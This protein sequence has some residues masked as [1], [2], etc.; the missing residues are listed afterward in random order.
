MSSWIKLIDPSSSTIDKRSNRNKRIHRHSMPAVIE[1]DSSDESCDLSATVSPKRRRI[2]P[3][4]NLTIKNVEDSSEDCY[5]VDYNPDGIALPETEQKKIKETLPVVAV[6]P[7]TNQLSHSARNSKSNS[8]ISWTANPKPNDEFSLIEIEDSVSD[9][10]ESS[11]HT[12]IDESST[13]GSLMQSQIVDERETAIETQ[14]SITPPVAPF[15]ASSTTNVPKKRK[16]RPKKGGLVE[17]LRK[18]LSQA[19]SDVLFWQHHRSADLIPPGI[20]VSVDRVENTYGRILIHA[21]VNGKPTIFS[22]CSRTVTVAEGDLIEVEF[23]SEHLY[24][25]DSRNLCS[26]VDK[27]TVVKKNILS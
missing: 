15:I 23:D 26:Y 19:K 27:V 7:A 12:L 18:S 22:L 20:L 14:E 2:L 9:S 3:L 10:S 8:W 16:V 1:D 6:R 4:E 25:T 17:Q 13:D 11:T 24:V 5:D 21:N